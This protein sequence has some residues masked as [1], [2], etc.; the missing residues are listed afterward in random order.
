[1][2]RVRA[3]TRTGSWI[4]V[5]SLLGL[6]LGACGGS[7]SSDD[8]AATS[9]DETVTSA[10]ED[11]PSADEAGEASESWRPDPSGVTASPE[12]TTCPDWPDVEPTISLQCWRVAVPMDYGDPG[13]KQIKLLV[14]RGHLEGA[15]ADA[16]P[17]VFLHGGPGGGA[18]STSPG[19]T[20]NAALLRDRDIVAI[21]ERG[22]DASDPQL[23]C[24]EFNDAMLDVLS[25]TASWEVEYGL[26][27]DAVVACRERVTAE[28]I[29]LNFF[30]TPHNTAD[31]DVVRRALSIEQWH[32]YG[33]S[34]GTRLALDYSRAFPDDVASVTIDSVYPPDLGDDMP[35][36]PRA[37]SA[38]QRLIAA[39]EADAA[40]GSA[41]PDLTGD[42]A[43]AIADLDARPERLPY[44]PAG[45][46]T[47]EMVISGSDLSGGLFAAM[48]EASVIPLLPSII[49]ALANGD[50]SIM[51]QFLT[52]GIPQLTGL[53]EAT[54]GAVDCADNLPAFDEQ[55]LAALRAD[56][57]AE[58]LVALGVA[59]TY[60]REWGV[61]PVNDEFLEPAVPTQPT[62]VVAGELD[63]ITPIEFSD[64]QAK[65]T[66]GAIEVVLP[67]GGHTVVV[68]SPCLTGVVADFW[69]DGSTVDTSC[70]A[71]IQPLPFS[72]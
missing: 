30:D 56:P 16:T 44:T 25:D 5:A 24:P 10:D 47:R 45:G 38:I 64:G 57:G 7:D 54:F 2:A 69:R 13:G 37:D 19:V 22:A 14:V 63:P 58:A 29:D 60:C 42:L 9:V 39:C 1:M 33:G 8:E 36:V 71:G 48:Y 27:R 3:V 32:V 53:S 34:Y 59:E 46:Q 62:L 66:P 68:D 18:L 21:S 61:E 41:Y 40:C 65:R 51:P 6:T 28:G 15:P 35:S 23:D 20:A 67:R 70:V 49:H 12:A 11:G 26:A 4:A 43:R 17:V 31:I 52:I 72:V 55:D 50:R